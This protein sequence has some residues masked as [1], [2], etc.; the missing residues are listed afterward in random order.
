[1]LLSQYTQHSQSQEL[2]SHCVLC[3]QWVASTSKI[4]THL[5]RTH[6]EVYQTFKAI[7]PGFLLRALAVSAASKSTIPN[8][9]LSTVLYCAS[10]FC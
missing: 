4:K 9:I 1:M 7:S 3:G 2:R 5:T 10:C 8:V 6:K